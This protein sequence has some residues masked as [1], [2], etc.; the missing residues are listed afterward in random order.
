LLCANVEAVSGVQPMDPP[1]AARLHAGRPFSRVGGIARGRP[2][3]TDCPVCCR[4]APDPA[5]QRM[6]VASGALLRLRSAPILVTF[7]G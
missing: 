2:W 1:A 7:C 4:R 3:V 6:V 5:L